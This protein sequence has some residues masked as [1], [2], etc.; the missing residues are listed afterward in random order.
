MRRWETAL[1]KRTHLVSFQKRAFWLNYSECDADMKP[2][3]RSGRKAL[4]KNFRSAKLG[5]EASGHVLGD[6]GRTPGACVPTSTQTAPSPPSLFPGS[7][8]PCLSRGCPVAVL[9]LSRGCPA[10][11]PRP[12]V[13]LGRSTRLSREE[14]RSRRGLGSPQVLQCL[15]RWEALAAWEQL[16]S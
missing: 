1:Q 9:W 14:A 16:F 7:A 5:L 6:C 2:H 10:M 15:G 3:V 8:V 11:G 13:A 4:T 12:A